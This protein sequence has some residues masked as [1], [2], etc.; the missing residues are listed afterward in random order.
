MNRAIFVVTLFSLVSFVG[1]AS[2]RLSPTR[3]VEKME[4][5]LWSD[6]NQ[7]HFE[8]TVVTPH[9][10]RTLELDVWMQRPNNTFIRVLSP[11]KERG[12]ASLRKGSEMWN[13]IPKIDR[14]VK[15]PP[16]MML[17][18][19]MGSNFSNDDLVKESSL[20]TDYTHVIG[21]LG[22]PE[23]G[24]VAYIISTAKPDAPVVWGKIE[25]WIHVKTGIPEKQVYFDEAGKPIREL[26]F[27][28]VRA[29][30]GR[31]LPTVWQMTP[32]GDAGKYTVVEIKKIAF[33]R[34]I[35]P[36]IFTERNLR[37][38]NW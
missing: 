20:A 31:L 1:V 21:D 29:M 4:K 38:Q 37:R 12:I 32:T 2:E 27:S 7:G 14:I 35:A 6:T 13:Y 26:V 25:S 24:D 16:S 3:L 28:A 17:Q 33:D 10:Q 36:A 22:K 23:R 19:W 9:W 18:A 5:L 8:M 34:A 15:I 11:K 30:D